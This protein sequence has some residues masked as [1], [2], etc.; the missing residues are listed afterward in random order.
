MDPLGCLFFIAAVTCLLLALQWGGQSKSWN[1]STIIGLFV[2]AGLLAGV[3]GFIQ[4]KRG[5][6]AMIPIRI[7]RQ[8]SI[9]AGGGVLFLTGA[10][11]YAVSIE[12]LDKSIISNAF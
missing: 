6:K 12:K 1:S 10:S 7:L 9:L 11:C 4:V 2:G 5:E 8:R 3:F